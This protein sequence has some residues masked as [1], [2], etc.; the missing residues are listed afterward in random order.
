M[1]LRS[2]SFVMAGFARWLRSTREHRLAHARSSTHVPL[3]LPALVF[4]GVQ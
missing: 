4:H 2:H 1:C 3:F